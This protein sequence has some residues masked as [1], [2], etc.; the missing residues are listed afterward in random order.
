MLRVHGKAVFILM[1]GCLGGSNTAP[2]NSTNVKL[3]YAPS[4]FCHK[5]PGNKVQVTGYML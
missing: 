1:E 5:N 4:F 3:E 2:E